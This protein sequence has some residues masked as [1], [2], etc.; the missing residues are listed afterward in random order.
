MPR[1]ADLNV[2]KYGGSGDFLEITPIKGNIGNQ[3]IYEG[4]PK[5]GEF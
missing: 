2:S 1:V 4:A 3:Y 5:L